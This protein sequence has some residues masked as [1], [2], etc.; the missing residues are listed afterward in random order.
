MIKNSV[1]SVVVVFL[2]VLLGGCSS[3]PQVEVPD[4]IESLEKLTVIPK[5]QEP[6]QTID[7]KQ[8]AVF[9]ETEE[10]LLGSIDGVT[11][12]EQGRVYLGDGD[13]NVIHAYKPSGQYLRKIGSE[14]KGPGEFTGIYSLRQLDDSLYAYDSQQDRVN[15]FSLDSFA[16]SHAVPLTRENKEIEELSNTSPKS[17]YVLGNG[18]L[19]V[20]FIEYFSMGQEEDTDRSTLF[21]QMNK[22]GEMISEKVLEQ[23][24]RKSITGTIGGGPV[25]VPAPF[26]RKS[27]FA[28]GPDNTF[29]GSWNEDFLIKKYNAEGEY[30]QAIYYPYTKSPLEIEDVLEKFDHEG[31]RDLLTNVERPATWPV[32]HSMKVDDQSRIWVSTITD[33]R[34][35]Y[36]W[37]VISSEGELLAKFNWPRSRSLKVVKDGSVYTHETDEETG[38]ERIVRYSIEMSTAD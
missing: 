23:K 33:D 14:G 28:G 27:L 30:Q 38:V 21:Y 26:G 15:V 20:S 10:V 19:L 29:Y 22:E 37:W 35:S 18:K 31:F 13:Q 9:G 4:D 7:F 6:A 12:D 8:T 34:D 25:V 11:V 17:F 32:I 24:A 1:T 16:F 3:E 36:R 2:I 5:D